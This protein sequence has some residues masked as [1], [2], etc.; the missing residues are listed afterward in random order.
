MTAR[1]PLSLQPS[2]LRKVLAGKAERTAAPKALPSAMR[3]GGPGVSILSF[4]IPTAPDISNR[5]MLPG[6]SDPFWVGLLA[7]M[8]TTAAVVVAVSMLVE[9]VGPFLGAM[10]VLSGLAPASIA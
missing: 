1:R 5:A 7:K 3:N 4:E 2:L 6:L 10:M 9:H 8:L